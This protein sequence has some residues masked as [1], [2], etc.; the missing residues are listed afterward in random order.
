MP[1][2]PGEEVYSLEPT[3][4]PG[5]L[6][7]MAEVQ[8]LSVDR[9]QVVIHAENPPP[10]LWE[11]VTVTYRLSWLEGEDSFRVEAINIEGR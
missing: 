1:A 3:E 4:A 2:S 11:D 8:V 6:P 10:A 9:S 7:F 5:I